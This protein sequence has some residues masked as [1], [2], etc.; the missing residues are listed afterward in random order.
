MA[1]RARQLVAGGPQYVV[2]TGGDLVTG[3]EA[4]DA[5]W[6]AGE[7]RY[8]SEPRRMG[9]NQVWSGAV[10]SAAIAARLAH[11]DSVVE[12]LAYAKGLVVRA[13]QDA[14]EWRIGH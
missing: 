5:V 8:K 9:G 1:L 11:G 12:A 7:Q 6:A 3:T 14:A 13:I 10:F 2:V 4:L